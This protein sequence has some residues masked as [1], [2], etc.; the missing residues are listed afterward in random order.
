ML[1]CFKIFLMTHYSCVIFFQNGVWGGVDNSSGY[2]KLITNRAPGNYLECRRD[3]RLSGCLF[4]WDNTS[5]QCRDGRHG[6]GN[7]DSL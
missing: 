5:A 1:N 2:R 3:G 4:Q 6:K 7:N